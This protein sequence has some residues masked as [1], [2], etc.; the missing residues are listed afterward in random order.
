MLKMKK[1]V[2]LISL[3]LLTNFVFAQKNIDKGNGKTV[4]PA[5]ITLPTMSV[6]EETF[7]FGKIPQGKPV[8][9]NFIVSNSASS[10]YKLTNVQASCGCT[11]PEWEKDK[12]MK[13][14]ESSNINVG[15]N[16]AAEGIFTKNITITYCDTLSKVITIKGEVWKTPA[17]SAPA[18]SATQDL[19]D[20]K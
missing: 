18:N 12:L 1:I 4:E 8:H 10:S 14:G 13:P 7:D 6:S 5:V 15:Y 11:T 3:P 20:R 2:F 17:A 16:A 19:K 9:H